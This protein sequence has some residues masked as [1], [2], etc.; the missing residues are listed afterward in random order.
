LHCHSRD[1]NI[2][3]CTWRDV[4]IEALDG[5]ILNDGYGVSRERVIKRMPSRK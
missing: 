1:H 3:Y 5:V 2:D 4:I